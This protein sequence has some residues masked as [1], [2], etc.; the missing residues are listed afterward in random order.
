VALDGK[1]FLTVRGP[2]GNLYTRNGAL[3]VS[4]KGELLAPEDRPVLDTKNQ[5]IVLDPSKTVNIDQTGTI[6][7]DGQSI[8]TLAIVEFPKPAGLVKSGQSYFQSPDTANQPVPSTATGILQGR[9]EESN[10]GP[11]ESAVR[12]V[13]V[14]RQFE[15]LQKAVSIGAD[16]NK[17]AI[18]EIAKVSQ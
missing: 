13:S 1:G 3:R 9:A 7:Q 15:M 5:P 18:S 8:A 10:A 12:L 2:K 11:G 4:S 17:E 14:L 16:M 6:T